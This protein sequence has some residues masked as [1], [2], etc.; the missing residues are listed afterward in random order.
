[1]WVKF[2]NIYSIT[3]RIL[4]MLAL[5]SI[6][7]TSVFFAFREGFKEVPDYQNMFTWILAALAMPGLM[8]Y[9]AKEFNPKT[10]AIEYQGQCPKCKRK[11]VMHLD[12]I[13]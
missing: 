9:Y 4:L 13:N 2:K 12:E 1:M 6:L 8:D 11:I 10:K 7:F 5:L 3:T